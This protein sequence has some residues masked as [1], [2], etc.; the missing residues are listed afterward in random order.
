[1]GEL[2]TLCFGEIL[3]DRIEGKDY[4]GGAPANVAVHLARLGARSYM[5]SSL[6]KDHLGDRAREILAGE[7]VRTDYV[8]TDGIRPTGRVEVT[9]REGIPDYRI[10]EDGA[11]DF[12]PHECARSL[13]GQHWDLL[14]CGSLSQRSAVSRETLALLL[15][16]LAYDH[17][18]FDVNLRQSFF[19]RE[20]IEGTMGYTSILKLSNGELPLLGRLLFGEEVGAR[21]FFSRLTERYDVELM[22][23]TRGPEGADFHFRSLPEEVYSIGTGGSPAVD[24]VGAG[25][26]FS[27]AFLYFFLTG[28]RLYRAAEKASLMADFVVSRSGALPPLE[29]NILKALGLA[30]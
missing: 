6:G 25:D 27:A 24:T 12:I 11:W 13:S 3:F 10:L 17:L 4:F 29:G 5:V 19:S 7:G 15:E 8:G 20:I 14:Y 16:T 30:I 26:S 1:M 2:K 22:I 9:L 28:D 18:F 21:T 23:L